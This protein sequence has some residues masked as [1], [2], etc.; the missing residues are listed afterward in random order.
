M[1]SGAQSPDTTGHRFSPDLFDFGSG[2]LPL[3]NS[4][5]A[6]VRLP[7]HASQPTTL[8]CRVHLESVVASI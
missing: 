8:E 7:I 3:A 1:V 2:E 4:M 6:M 5:H